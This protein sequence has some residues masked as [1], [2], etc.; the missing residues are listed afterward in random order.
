M[1]KKLFLKN[2]DYRKMT[3]KIFNT[4]K[5]VDYINKIILLLLLFVINMNLLH[6]YNLYLV[7]FMSSNLPIFIRMIFKIGK[8]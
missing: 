7:L 2:I 8:R 6:F 5:F 1:T 4:I 3:K